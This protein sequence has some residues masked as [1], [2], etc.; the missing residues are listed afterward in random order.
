MTSPIPSFRPE[1]DHLLVV[2]R[3]N[4]DTDCL[5]GRESQLPGITAFVFPGP[6]S[7]VR[8][9]RTPPN[10]KLADMLYAGGDLV[11]LPAEDA[12][13]SNFPAAWRIPSCSSPNRRPTSRR[14][15][16]S[17]WTARSGSAAWPE[18][19]NGVS[20]GASGVASC[21]S[22]VSSWRVSVRGD[23]RGS[24]RSPIRSLRRPAAREM[25]RRHEPVT[26]CGRVWEA[27][28]STPSVSGS[29]APCHELVTNAAI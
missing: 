29:G 14:P 4:S 3:C 25:R 17:A 2:R 7:G 24:T 8:T 10:R 15:R 19:S 18:R 1:W 27:E 23:V 16:R 20:R 13:S 28:C 6:V 5:Q 26:R 11:A 9:T 21:S 22:A 12:T